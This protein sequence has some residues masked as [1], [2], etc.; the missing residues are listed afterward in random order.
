MPCVVMVKSSSLMV[1]LPSALMALPPWLVVG[2]VIWKVPPVMLMSVS[3][4][5]AVQYAGTFWLLM[6]SS[7]VLP[8]AVMVMSPPVMVTSLVAVMPLEMSPEWVSSKVP[9]LMWTVPSL[10]MHL[11]SCDEE[12]TVMS[13]VP[14][15]TTSV[16]DEM[17]CEPVPVI[18]TSTVPPLI[19]MSAS[20]LMPLQSLPLM[21]R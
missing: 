18:C 5:M 11:P 2:R 9:P 3:L 10:L 7:M 20:P 13:A 15:M 21:I 1:R 8:D 6:F 16:S 17:P 4:L 19:L 14:S 12:T